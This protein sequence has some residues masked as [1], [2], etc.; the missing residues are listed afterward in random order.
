MDA[1]P[2]FVTS[3][4][5][6]SSTSGSSS[7][8]STSGGSDR[9]GGRHG[10]QDDDPPVGVSSG[11]CDGT[12]SCYTNLDLAAPQLYGLPAGSIAPFTGGFG[13]QTDGTIYQPGAKQTITNQIAAVQNLVSA[14]VGQS[15]YF[16]VS[17][18]GL[19]SS[20]G[21]DTP[22]IVE[23]TDS[24]N[25]QNPLTGYG[26]LVVDD[27]LQINSTLQ[28][29]GLVVVTSKTGQVTVGSGAS[30]Q[31]IGALLLQ[32]GAKLNFPAGSAQIP[33][34]QISYSCEAIDLPFKKRPFKVISTAET[35]F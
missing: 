31:I 32:P 13:N 5:S 15:N 11:L 34:F 35:S 2:R 3:G 23:I 4:S 24:I 10:G 7:S 25:L 21:E 12:A 30:G 8:G 22:A 14:S 6:S 29:T 19:A 28:W 9:D 20:Y 18:A 17:A 1:S 16:K 27:S 26:I 33:S